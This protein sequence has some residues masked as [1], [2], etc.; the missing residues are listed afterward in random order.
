L[1]G[2]LIVVE[3]V[4][5]SGEYSVLII[6]AAVVLLPKA[7]EPA[8]YKDLIESMLLAQLAANKKLEKTADIDWY[9]AYMELLDNYWLRHSRARR[10]WTVGKEISGSVGDWVVAAMCS[11]AV[12]NGGAVSLALQQLTG[13]SGTE[14]AMDLLRRHMQKI[15]PA[16]SADGA[17]CAKAVRLLVAV[18]NTPTSVT[19]VYLELQTGQVLGSNPLAEQFQAGEVHGSVCMRYAAACL[20]ETLYASVREAIALKIKDRLEDNVAL[21]TLADEVIVAAD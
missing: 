19:S 6:G 14:P 13:L 4:E 15:S 9:N 18:A 11:E 10:D 5:V 1:I 16:Q 7:H 3:G 8:R 17:A 12:D 21:L 2:C 20:S